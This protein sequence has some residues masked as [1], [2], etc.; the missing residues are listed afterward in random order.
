MIIIAIMSIMIVFAVVVVLAAVV[1]F[2]VMA[3]VI[4]M[5]IMTIVTVMPNV[6]VV[7]YCSH[8]GHCGCHN[9]HDC[10][11]HCSCCDRPLKLL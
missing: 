4:N 5:V 8:G 3:V 1:I 6:V 2:A 9:R 11:V 7:S 10:C